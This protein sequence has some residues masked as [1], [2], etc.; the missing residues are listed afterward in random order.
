MARW[1]VA[2]A[3]W[4]GSAVVPTTNVFLETTVGQAG[5]WDTMPGLNHPA[6]VGL[7]EHQPHKLPTH[8]TPLAD[9]AIS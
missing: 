5:D 9:P 3:I 7:R 2:P 4:V 1:V 8:T 6:L